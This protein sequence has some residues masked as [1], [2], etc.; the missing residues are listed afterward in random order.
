MKIKTDFVTNSS[1]TCF[2]VMTKGDFTLGKFLESAGIDENSPFNDM[3]RQIFKLF[4]GNMTPA[5][6]FAANHRWNQ[7]RSFEK[8]ISEVF[9]KKTLQRVKEAEAAGMT[10]YMGDL[11]SDNGSLE[12][13]LCTDCFVIDTPELV[14]D[15]TNDGW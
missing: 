12:C 13:F 3:F 11:H 8:F 4:K 2:V 5:R 6:E 7:G 10:I 9:S 1:S 15:A 14:I